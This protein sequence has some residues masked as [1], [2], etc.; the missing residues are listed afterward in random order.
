MPTRS[1]VGCLCARA[2]DQLPDAPLFRPARC[3]G[4]RASIQSTLAS[5]L[6]EAHVCPQH[7]EHLG[8]ASTSRCDSRPS[9]NVRA[10]A[11]KMRLTR[12]MFLDALRDL[13]RPS[14]LAFE[15]V[16][17]FHARFASQY[18][19]GIVVLTGYSPCPDDAYMPGEQAANF[20][21]RW[22]MEESQRAAMQ[23]AGIFLTHAH[24]HRGKPWFSISDSKTN[25]TLV[26]PISRIDP[27]LPSGALLLSQDSAVALVATSEGFEAVR[28]VAIVGQK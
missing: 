20:D 25:T 18:E 8:G 17:V 2:H 11:M 21:S 23:N 14:P 1:C 3:A 24:D 9:P 5:L 26:Y 19:Q 22:L 7:H 4:Q 15:R 13:S 16:A 12:V 10:S 6:G 27:S 28:A